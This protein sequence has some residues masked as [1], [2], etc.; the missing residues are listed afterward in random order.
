[1]SIPQYIVVVLVTLTLGTVGA[2]RNDKLLIA[3]AITLQS[4]ILLTA[5]IKKQEQ[6]K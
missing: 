2:I 4:S 1:M 3:L 5:E 6:S